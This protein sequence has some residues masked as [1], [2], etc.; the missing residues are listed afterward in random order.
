MSKTGGGRGTNQYGRKGVGKRASTYQ[1]PGP[2]VTLDVPVEQTGWD[3]SST[4]HGETPIDEDAREFL[5]P[6]CQGI[7]TLDELNA[8]ESEGIA[9]AL[10]WLRRHPFES[11][12]D[13][14]DQINLRDLHRRMFEDVW[15]WAGKIRRRET[16]IGVAPEMISQDWAISLGNTRAQIEFGTYPPEEIG[17]RFHREMVAIHCFVNG[18]GR[19]ARIAA[20]EL[21][22]LLGLGD[23]AF[24][25]GRRGGD[26]PEIV[27]VRYLEALS[28]A[29]T[30]G[31]YGPLVKIAIS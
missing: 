19:H 27:R 16:N 26:S 20:N 8:L 7:A 17:V 1:R 9:V 3:I 11:A 2:E 12:D 10:S 13:L 24:T 5:T 25:W 4:Q 14:L 31:D 28:I 15:T 18:N 30:T 21:G 23:N 22:R 6:R 29:D